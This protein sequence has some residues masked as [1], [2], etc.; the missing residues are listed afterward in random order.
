MLGLYVHIPFC[1]KKCNYCDFASFEYKKRETEEKYIDALLGEIAKLSS[2]E[3]FDTVYVGGGTPTALSL[4]GLERVLKGILSNI[5]ISKSAE[6]TVEINPMTVNEDTIKIFKEYSVNRISMGIQSTNDDELKYLGRIHNW[7]QAKDTYNL[8]RKGGIDN[9]NCDL[10]FG[11]PGQ[12][13]KGVE[14]SLKDIINLEPEHISC[15]GLKI[16]QGTSFYK[17]LSHGRLKEIPDD[18][19]ADMYDMIRG[20]MKRYNMCQYEISNFSKKGYESRH[21]LLYWTQNSYYGAGLGASSFI[22]NVRYTN[23]NKLDDYINN[24]GFIPL[25][26]KTEMNKNELMSEFMILGLRLTEVGADKDRFYKKFGLN[27]DDV[28]GD[29]INKYKKSGFINST[30]QKVVLTEKAYYVSNS[31]LCDFII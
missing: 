11:V 31:I 12:T 10:M 1:V 29:V 3:I 6:F 19:Y 24:N 22:N 14:S 17:M 8:L 30:H 13:I 21:N 15:Y 28:F 18:L 23:T 5:N 20:N 4:K 16:E 7:E 27:M 26:E 2:E 9:I 25:S